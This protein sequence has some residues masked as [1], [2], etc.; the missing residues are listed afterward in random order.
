M[1][2]K[3][4]V[5]M[6]GSSGYD[7]EFYTTDMQGNPVRNDRTMRLQGMDPMKRIAD[8]QRQESRMET[9]MDNGVPVSTRD[10]ARALAT[11]ASMN[12]KRGTY[13]ESKLQDTIERD[14]NKRIDSA[15][16]RGEQQAETIATQARKAYVKKQ[17]GDNSFKPF[18][19]TAPTLS[20]QIMAANAKK[21]R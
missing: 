13:S 12:E 3:R 4:D 16:K 2:K 5:G 18:T 21:K 20:K 15:I 11:R 9:M 8:S 6:A 17:V 19:K 14:D 1:A 10:R 7:S